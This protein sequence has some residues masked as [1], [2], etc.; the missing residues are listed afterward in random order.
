MPTDMKIKI[1]NDRGNQEQC[2]QA[3]NFKKLFFIDFHTNIR[4]YS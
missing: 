1:T 4:K 2:K 3:L